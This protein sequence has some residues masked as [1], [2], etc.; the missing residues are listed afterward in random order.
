MWEGAE[1]D[2][3]RKSSSISK[4]AA[5]N[6]A[7]TPPKAIPRSSV[8]SK[9]NLEGIADIN[10]DQ[11]AS[12]NK[13]GDWR[14]MRRIIAEDPEWSLATVPLLNELVIK[15]IVQ[16]FEHKSDVLKKL[17][18]KDQ[19]KVLAQISTD[20]PLKVT[21]LLIDDE[22]FWERCCRARWELCD[23]SCHG[24]SWKCMYLER[25]LQQ[26]IE[27]YVPEATDTDE[28]DDVLTLSSNFI[29][30]IDI[31]QLLPPVPTVSKA[32]DFDEH[33]DALSDTGDE[34][35]S[36]HFNFGPVLKRLP[37]LEEFHVTYGVRD[38]GMNFE[39]NFFQFTAKDCLQLS[40]CI[41]GL[42]NLKVF[43]LHKSK[44]DDEKAR[45]LISHILDHPGL[46]ELDLSHNIIGDRGA[47]AIG[48]FLN[49]HSKLVKL[50]LCDN[51]IR[52]AGAQ[53]I[54]HALTKNNLL[55]S[56]NLR[57]NRLGDEGGQA[58]CRA[59]MKNR[60]LVELNL[61]GND[62][63]EPSAVLMSQVLMQNPQL[64]SIDLSCNRLG[65]DGGKHL[66]EGMEENETV[67]HMDLRL[68]ECG[69]EAE[70]CINQILLRNQEA[71]R[72]KR[73]EEN[74]PINAVFY[75]EKMEPQAAHRFRLPP[76]AVLF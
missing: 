50:N 49:N 25:H 63:M 1:T 24:N 71:D 33:S 44:V 47:R 21:A 9:T 75:K 3:D 4:I 52:V 56:L 8:G 54:A 16:N 41:A 20:L 48:K 15:H 76:A 58:I 38:C 32:P 23:V 17:L 51:Q 5:S 10:P 67:I 68:T 55:Q 26:L 69:Q 65:I 19:T 36:D 59:L 29:K 37:F 64:R 35:E 28:I 72:N 62:L 43:R 27:L 18:T 60:T 22:G 57:L 39:W 7:V 11:S 30:K 53:A 74:K 40:E 66:Q 73:I 70:F 13:V 45:V 61:C 34:L 31:R 6:A 46:V 14:N 42:P 2:I 12:E